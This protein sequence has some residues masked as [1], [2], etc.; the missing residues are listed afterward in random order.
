MTVLLVSSTGAEFSGLTRHF[1]VTRLA[2]PLDYAAVL[3][4]GAD[5]WVLVAN[6]AGAAL[7]LE[8]FT[9]ASQRERLH[10]VVSTGY[11]GALDPAI[12]IAEIVTA[13]EVHDGSLVFPAQS[14]THPSRRGGVAG[15]DHVV[16]SAAEKRELRAQTG[17]A[18]VDMESHALARAAQLA[19]LPFYC[20]RAVTDIARE[21]M[22]L[23]FNAAR[24]VSGR[25]RAGR[26]LR[27]SLRRPAA[28]FPELI[29]MAFRAR[30]ASNELGDFLAAC[31]F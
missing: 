13:T 28:T 1:P 16:A 25:I 31:R 8:A 9:I 18:T 24:D 6:G 4:R 22:H 14:P 19:G 29:K 26:L 23:D 27:N 11:C 12:A 7:A 2:W 5:R 3:E 20:I 15:A 10:A 30:R 17:A 21:D